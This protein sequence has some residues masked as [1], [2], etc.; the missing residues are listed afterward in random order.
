MIL[1]IIC[2]AY[3]LTNLMFVFKNLPVGGTLGDS[4]VMLFSGFVSF[5]I[6]ILFSSD[7]YQLMTLGEKA[8]IK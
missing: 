4:A 1:S 6:L 5:L 7:F 3:A 8:F 2:I